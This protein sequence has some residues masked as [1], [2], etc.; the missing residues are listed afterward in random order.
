MEEREGGGG[1]DR[2]FSNI[3]VGNLVFPPGERIACFVTKSFQ[4]KAPIIFYTVRLYRVICGQK[5]RPLSKFR[6]PELLS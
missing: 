3:R 1:G 4:D 5:S 2:I 6:R